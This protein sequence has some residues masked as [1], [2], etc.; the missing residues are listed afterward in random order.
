MEPP[1]TAVDAADAA[2]RQLPALHRRVGVAP[3]EPH[4]IVGLSANTGPE[5]TAEVKAAGMNGSMSKPFYPA[6]LRATLASVRQGTYK[7]F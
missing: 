6:T 1:H 7:G 5:Y 2:G 4:V 3:R